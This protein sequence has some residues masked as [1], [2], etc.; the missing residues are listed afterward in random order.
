MVV[1]STLAFRLRQVERFKFPQPKGYGTSKSRLNTFMYKFFLFLLLLPSCLLAQTAAQNKLFTIEIGTFHQPKLSDF[2]ALKDIGLVYATAEEGQFHQIFMGGFKKASHAKKILKQVKNKGYAATLQKKSFQQGQ[3]AVVIQL[4]ST[5]NRQSLQWASLEKAG[6]LYSLLEHPQ[7]LKLVTGPFTNRTAALNRITAIQEMGFKDAF[8]KT[9]NIQLLTPIGYFEKGIVPT[10]PTEM[11]VDEIERI[12]ATTPEEYQRSKNGN[13]NVPIETSLPIQSTHTTKH[14][15]EPVIPPTTVLPMPI[16]DGTIKRTAALDLQTILKTEGYYKGPLDGYYGQGTQ[17]GY[18]QF[19]S[20]N[21]QYNKYKVLANYLNTS[22]QPAVNELQTILNALTNKD[23]SLIAALERNKEPIAKAYLAYWLLVNQGSSRE[24]NQLM[25][26]AI[27]ESFNKKTNKKSPPFDATA[28]Y[29]Y[30]ELQQ[31]LLHI[32]YLHTAPMNTQYAIPCWLFEAHPQ[33]AN[34]VFNNAKL[35]TLAD[36]KLSGCMRFEEWQPI[37]ILRSF[38]VELQPEQL[39]P[40]EVEMQELLETGRSFF[41][42]FPEK[43]TVTQKKEIDR[44]KVKLWKDL[45]KTATKNPL[46]E[47]YA[48]TLKILF[49]QSQ[50]LIEDYYMQRGFSAEEAEG[51]ALSVLKT[52]TTIPLKAYLNKK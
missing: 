30:I 20:T 8:I 28:S 38:L 18:H 14:I 16:I 6:K 50:I 34:A 24:V 17:A 23:A 7:I 32:R 42:L 48:P 15:P 29:D 3:E 36:L 26:T 47:K 9:I 31:L 39:S 19:Q 11:L 51:L 21:Y 5:Q 13:E 2:A 27:R 45:Q 35:A 37:A 40:Q 1:I 43:L 22:Q 33:A 49:F 10:S 12:A 25:N 44:W 41:Y 46:L 52:Y 4:L